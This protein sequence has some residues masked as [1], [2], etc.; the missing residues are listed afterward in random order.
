MA[1]SELPF[2][3]DEVFFSIDQSQVEIDDEGRFIIKDPEL[4]DKLKAEL[5]EHGK[6]LVASSQA[7]KGNILCITIG[8]IGRAGSSETED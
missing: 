2:G 4:M 3:L 7:Q 1:D 8:D 6:I 5:D